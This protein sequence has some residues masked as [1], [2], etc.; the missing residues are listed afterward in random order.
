MAPAEKE[1]MLLRL[2]LVQRKVDL[3][4]ST[5]PKEITRQA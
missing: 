5:D 2:K 3:E 4:K 1:D